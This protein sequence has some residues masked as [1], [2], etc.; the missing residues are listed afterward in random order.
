MKILFAVSEAAPFV[1]TG[2]LG[3][4]AY[5]LPKALAA[6]G[7]EVR[8]FIPLYGNVKYNMKFI[9]ELQYLTDTR[10][11][12]G[13]RNQYNGIFRYGRG[14]RN[15]EYYFIDNEYYFSR[16]DGYIYGN[17]D[18]GERF[19][20]FSRAVIDAMGATGFVPDIIHCND[21]QTAL[22]PVFLRR[23]YPQYNG[24]RTVFTIHNIEYQGKMPMEF[25]A[26]VL[27]LG[28]AQTLEY[29]GCVN[30]M[31]GAIVASDA[32]TTVSETYAQ[33]IMD[34]FYSSGLHHILRDNRAKLHGILNG[35][36]TAAFDPAT[37]P[38]LFMNYS[39]KLAPKRRNKLFLQEKLRLNPSEKQPLA[40]IISRLV[41]HKGM[42]IAAEAIDGVIG[43]GVQLAVLGT[44]DKC[45]ENAFRAAAE[46]HPGKMA[47]CIAFDAE[48]ASQMYAAADIFLMPS[49]SEPCGLS[50]MVAMRYGCV[51]VVRETGGL[52]DTVPAYD[53][54][55]KTGSGFTFV[56]YTTGELLRAV[57]RCA[58]LYREEH[59]AFEAMQLHN[60]R[61]DFSWDKPVRKYERLYESLL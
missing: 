4:V 20:F 46:R 15:P 16:A 43:G 52:K 55:K 56:D 36:D 33:Q 3:D 61:R 38:A 29:D 12:L 28:G 58:A 5:A 45:F 2:G 1:K 13:W 50:Q 37:D 10:T 42:D 14:G 30:L 51:P 41:R 34:E 19:A 40:V 47:A 17:Y 32:V 25:A 6:A 60:M 49:L 27:G 44:G 48:L 35:I 54:E 53:P 59:P 23:F 18:D 39:D 9:P 21:W 22:I 31:K 8:V 26:E 11:Q 57:E 24:V 7:H